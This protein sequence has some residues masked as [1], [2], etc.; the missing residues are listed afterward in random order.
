MDE[1]DDYGYILYRLKY[2]SKKLFWSDMF[3]VRGG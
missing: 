1:R 2:S 3:F